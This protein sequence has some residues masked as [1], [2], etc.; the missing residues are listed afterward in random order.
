VTPFNSNH[1]ATVEFG[2]IAH[3]QQIVATFTQLF[4]VSHFI[5]LVQNPGI[6]AMDI[7]DKLE[8]GLV[9]ALIN[10]SLL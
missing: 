4:L 8:G 9:S 10:V 7:T 6:S 3:A 2:S 1:D 5:V